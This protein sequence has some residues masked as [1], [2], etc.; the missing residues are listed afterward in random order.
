MDSTDKLGFAFFDQLP[1]EPYTTSINVEGSSEKVRSNYYATVRI[2]V[3]ATVT[4]G[5][6]TVIEFALNEYGKMLVKLERTDGG[7]D[8][9]KA[10]FTVSSLKHTPK[11]PV[12]PGEYE[13]LKPTETYTVRCELDEAFRKDFKLEE[14]E[15]TGQTV[16]AT[17][18]TTVVFPVT[19]RY[20]V[21]L[22]LVDPKDEGLTGTFRFSQKAKE[23]QTADAVGRAFRHVPDLLPGTVDV[24]DVV[25]AESQ[26]FASI[27]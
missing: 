18:L 8:L 6:I 16:T 26:E 15:M 20:W 3:P 19:P 21:E 24:L 1:A 23:P 17:K 27:L 22:A 10:T 14:A 4:P 12:K 2:S 25:L 11:A 9:P 13:Q 5:K 7:T